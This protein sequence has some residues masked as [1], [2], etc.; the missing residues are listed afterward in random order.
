[1]RIFIFKKK[2]NNKSGDGFTLIEMVAVVGI[3][4]I[5]SAIVLVN[6]RSGDSQLALLRSANKLSQD[7]RRAQEMAMSAEEVNNKVYD[8][9]GIH[10]DINPGVPD[11]KKSYIL[12]GDD[13]GNG[14]YQGDPPD[15]PI[16]TVN[17]EKN[18]EINQILAS[19][20]GSENSVQKISITFQPPDPTTYIL[21]SGE[22][23]IVVK[24]QLISGSNTKTVVV[25]KAGL[26]YVE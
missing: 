15:K 3:I 8:R 10:F 19:A 4:V 6:Y 1:M 13:G 9:Y 23:K 7:I 16:E 14:A 2:I 12:F 20:G 25:N 26:I 21:E 22:N 24:I 17:F 5:L 11:G 18:V